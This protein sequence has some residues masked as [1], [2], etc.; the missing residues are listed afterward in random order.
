MELLKEM[1][2]RVLFQIEVVIEGGGA[3]IHLPGAVI[4]L[5][6]NQSCSPTLYRATLL[7]VGGLTGKCETVLFTISNE[8]QQ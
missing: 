8:F 1:I 4:Q 7:S 6:D 3:V 2:E 5:S